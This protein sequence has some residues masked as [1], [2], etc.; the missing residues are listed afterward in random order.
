MKITPEIRELLYHIQSLNITKYQR[1]FVDAILQRGEYDDHERTQLNDI[2]KKYFTELREI[3]S[4]LGRI[5]Y[6]AE[7]SSLLS[8]YIKEE[9]DKEIIKKIKNG[10]WYE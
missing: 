5:D 9:I 7:L 2:R 3:Y 1:I 10:G 6:E 4:S 8:N